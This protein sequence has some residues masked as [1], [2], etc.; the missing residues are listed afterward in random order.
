MSSIV[1][2]E[3]L[4][5]LV[6]FSIAVETGS[7]AAAGRKLGLSAS[8]VGK[9][10]ERLEARLGLRLLNRT[11]RSL[12]VTGE[13]DILYRYVSRILKELQDAEQELHLVQKAPRGRLKVSV[14][15]VLGRKIV[16]PALL[17][18]RTRFPEVTTEISLDDVKVDI[19]EGGYDVVLRLGELDDSTL[20]ARRI[21]PHTFTTCAS[22]GYLAHRGI[23]QSPADLHNHCCIYYRFPTTGRPEV[24]A[25][26]NSPHATPIKPSTILND[27]E[28]LASAALGGLGII[29]VP[30]YLV[31]DDIAAGRL[32]T[33]LADYT[34]E[35]GS[36]SLVW[37]PMS[38]RAPKVRAFI[39]F[40]AERVS[41][42][43]Y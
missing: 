14:P 24:W 5:G 29:Q 25:F 15:T 42:K 26:K 34:D 4:S 18:F 6:A 1:S 22:P 28:A 12:A 20:R 37:P 30:S 38:A 41:Q 32:Q 43:L 36:V 21:G 11:T 17:D 33:I 7:F 23:P 27:G 31:S 35:R 8:A 40:M 2:I 13:G 3:S 19:I 39:D 16:M 10:V 9:A